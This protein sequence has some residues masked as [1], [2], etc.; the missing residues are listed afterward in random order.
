M[1]AFTVPLL[2]VL[3]VTSQCINAYPSAASGM[4]VK[5]NHPINLRL[6]RDYG[7]L[8]HHDLANNYNGDLPLNIDEYL[9][10]L[11]G[12]SISRQNR[13]RLIDF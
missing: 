3:L 12:G 4:N 10:Y 9:P 5:N 7:L 13:K 11:Y 6:K 2:V 8:Q 1:I